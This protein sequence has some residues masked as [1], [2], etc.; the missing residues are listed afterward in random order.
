[1]CIGNADLHYTY[2][3]LTG[4]G[5]GEKKMYYHNRSGCTVELLLY[6]IFVTPSFSW[7]KQ[8]FGWQIPMSEQN[9]GRWVLRTVLY[10]LGFSIVT[11]DILLVGT[12]KCIIYSEH[13]KCISGADEA[14]QAFSFLVFIRLCCRGN[15]STTYKINTMPDLLYTAMTITILKCTEY[16]IYFFDIGKWNL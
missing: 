4:S 11:F 16:S 8:L 5:S 13:R 9:Q 15:I 12:R 2:K 10:E 6:Y 1:M 7:R 14:L 3:L